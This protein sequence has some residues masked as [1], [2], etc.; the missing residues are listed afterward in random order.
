[1]D[2]KTRVLYQESIPSHAM[3]IIGVDIVGGKPEKWLVE[4][5]WGAKAGN[6]GL[7]AMYDAWFEEY[8]YTVII[9]RKHLPKQVS[10]I[11]NQKAVEIPPW[12]PMF[13]MWLN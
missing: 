12:D 7:F 11:F 13:A 6:S 3:L 4:N 1:M 5:S 9:H 2:K 10:D 8:N